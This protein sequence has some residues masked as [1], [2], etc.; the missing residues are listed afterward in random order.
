MIVPRA[1]GR[2]RASRLALGAA[3]VLCVLLART[4][5]AADVTD[6]IMASVAPDGSPSAQ[7]LGDLSRSFER[8]SGG[9][10]RIKERFGGVLGDEITTFGDCQKGRVQLWAGSVSAA[11]AAVP[12]VTVLDTPYLVADLGAYGRGVRGDV[13]DGPLAGRAFRA[14]GIVPFAAGF[15]GWRSISTRE[16][17]VRVP[18]DL[19]G[20]RM[21]SLPSAL[22]ISLWRHLGA[23]PKVT[24][25]T[26]VLSTFREK[27]VDAVDLQVVYLFAT[28]LVEQIRHHTRSSHMAQTAAVFINKDA[29]GRL[30]KRA[31]GELLRLRM[32]WTA[33]SN[34]VHGA[35]EDE[36]VDAVRA[37][38]VQV[39]VPT[40]AEQ[41]A[42]RQATAP[43]AAEALR[44]GGP[45]GAEIIQAVQAAR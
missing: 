11:E 34:K 10:I 45:V 33:R 6:W 12:G 19:R 24:A 26:E 31:Q 2:H 17:P 25:L 9:R 27:L 5:G 42:W 40:A 35:L 22:H 28:S 13:L 32:E 36:L 29:F 44:R 3:T 23:V 41:A 18:A 1:A 21:R 37:A 14:H 16:K 8:A 43:L 7:L 39:I 15:V 38:G 4:T 30:S 20:L